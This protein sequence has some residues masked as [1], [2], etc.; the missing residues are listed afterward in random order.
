M[1][2]NRAAKFFWHLQD[3]YQ[4][5]KPCRFA[6]VVAIKAQSCFWEL[7]KGGKSYARWTLRIPLRHAI[8]R[9]LGASRSVCAVPFLNATSSDDK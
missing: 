2:E 5:L 6:F 7:S 4:E 8:S 3:I 9:S 1:S